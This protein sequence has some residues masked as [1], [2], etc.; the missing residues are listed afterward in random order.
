ML[1]SCAQLLNNLETKPADA[2]ADVIISDFLYG[3]LDGSDLAQSMDDMRRFDQLEK[4]TSQQWV[5]L[6]RK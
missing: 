3:K 2:F 4:Y 5:D 6:L 1:A